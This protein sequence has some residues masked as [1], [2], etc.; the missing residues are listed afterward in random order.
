MLV[1]PGHG[2]TLRFIEY[3]P[4]QLQTSD[5][6]RFLDRLAL[7]FARV[8]QQRRNTPKHVTA[9]GLVKDKTVWYV[10][11]TK[12]DGFD[13]VD[14]DFGRELEKW[15]ALSASEDRNP[16]PKNNLWQRLLTFWG[17]RIDYYTKCAKE[18]DWEEQIGHKKMADCK[19]DVADHFC[20]IMRTFDR[21]A[22]DGEWDEVPN[23]LQQ[24]KNIKWEDVPDTPQRV[25]SKKKDKVPE[26]HL[27][28][29]SDESQQYCMDFYDFWSRPQRQQYPP[30]RHPD[31]EDQ[32][33]PRESAAN[34]YCKCVYYLDMLAMPVSIWKA[35]VL[36]RELKN[37]N[38]IRVI[39][40][41]KPIHIE[42]R[43][44]LNKS[45]VAQVLEDW[46]RE[47]T[48]NTER[49]LT[50]LKV[51]LERTQNIYLHCELQILMLF[52]QVEDQSHLIKHN[53][54]GCSK[55]SCWLCWQILREREYRTRGTHGTISANWNFPFPKS[56]DKM[57]ESFV[58]L[59]SRW[60]ALFQANPNGQLPRWPRLLDTDPASTNRNTFDEVSTG[61]GM[62]VYRLTQNTFRTTREPSFGG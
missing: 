6:D 46:K 12:N 3:T 49:A 38:T 24:V 37:Q 54:I 30:V 33:S 5:I 7:L 13:G 40:V 39:L 29:L 34:I 14:K 50:T 18:I 61:A 45:A 26:K 57:V 10:C 47:G 21:K 48:I 17:D 53:F 27:R 56:L 4:R 1:L 35:M 51:S 62:F 58:A 9:A 55:L 31:S 20:D 59:G 60:E 16:S 52:H 11:M 42:S 8:K 19:S 44:Q 36:F 41:E 2:L 15:F 23:R 22:F 32:L 25:K 43:G 28:K